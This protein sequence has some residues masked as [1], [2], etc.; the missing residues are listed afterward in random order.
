M[1]QKN[2]FPAL[3]PEE[4]QSHHAPSPIPGP[5]QKLPSM[6]TSKRYKPPKAKIFHAKKR[7]K[8]RTIASKT[9]Y[10]RVSPVDII[11]PEVI[12]CEEVSLPKR[13]K[14]EDKLVKKKKK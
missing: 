7:S 14:L 1:E 4:F 3:P 10:R 12:E 8:S 2:I 6:K 5:S 11:D 9:Y 13:R